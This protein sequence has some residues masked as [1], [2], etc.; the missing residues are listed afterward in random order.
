MLEELLRHINNR[1]ERGSV[2]GTFTVEDGGIEA[3]GL[4]DGQYYWVEGS[5]LNDGLHLHP[6]S[7]MVAETF[8]GRVV[9]LAVP[10]VVV[11]L[12][13]EI[14]DWCD[15]NT[16]ALSGPYASESFGGYSYT[17]AGVQSGGTASVTGWQAHFATRLN[18]F[19]K[20]Y[21]DWV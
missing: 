3:E 14:E 8:T 2:S 19:R 10:S 18:P 6:A 9:M 11:E 16:K 20:L 21:R 12:A 15:D 7:D 4:L 5:V 1:F 17:K 13:G